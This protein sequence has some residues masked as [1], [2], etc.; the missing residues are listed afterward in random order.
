MSIKLAVLVWKK[1]LENRRKIESVLISFID[2]I[3]KSYNII[4]TEVKFIMREYYKMAKNKFGEVKYEDIK[5]FFNKVIYSQLL[6]PE[7]MRM[8]EEEN[9]VSSNV[10]NFNIPIIA[11]F[12][13]K[14]LYGQEFYDKQKY[15]YFNQLIT[16]YSK[17]IQ[18]FMKNFI[19]DIREQNIQMKKY[20]NNAFLNFSFD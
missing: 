9:G 2:E 7:F 4:P 13:Q 3:L 10:K 14:I 15:T 8:L 18:E 16:H 17:P 6:L 5:T 11:L 1:I 12:S 20:M 19:E